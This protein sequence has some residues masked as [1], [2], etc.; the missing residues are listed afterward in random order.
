MASFR[1]FDEQSRENPC[2]GCPAPCCRIQ[3]LFYP[4]PSKF[5]DLDQARYRL[6]APG[7]ELILSD[8]NDWLLLHWLTCSLFA[9][10]TCSCSVHGTPAKPKVCVLANPWDCWFKLNFVG[11]VP[12][13]IVRLDLARF[14]AWLEAVKLGDDGAIESL[15]SFEQT[16]EIVSQ[17]PIQPSFG[18]IPLDG[19]AEVL[20]LDAKKG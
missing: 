17:L 20:Q 13:S 19:A 12:R 15:P 16:R 10:G 5:M 4:T 1:S 6:L 2:S 8:T 7:A 14:D 18:A 11:E 3:L 9:E